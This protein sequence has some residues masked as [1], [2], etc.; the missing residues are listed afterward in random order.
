MVQ[1]SVIAIV[2]LFIRA[3][4]KTTVVIGFFGQLVFVRLIISIWH[5]MN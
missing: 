2:F 4:V 1:Q 3:L 5:I